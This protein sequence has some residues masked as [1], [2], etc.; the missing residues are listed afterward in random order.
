MLSLQKKCIKA[1][2]EKYKP[3]KLPTSPSEVADEEHNPHRPRPSGVSPRPPF[4]PFLVSLV[5]LTT[6]Q[7]STHANQIAV[8]CHLEEIRMRTTYLIKQ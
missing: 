7:C 1:C 8:S 3:S 5:C 6:I 4:K 2:H